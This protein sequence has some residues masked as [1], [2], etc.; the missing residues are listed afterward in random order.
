MF[1]IT[2]LLAAATAAPLPS[3]GDFDATFKTAPPN[4]VFLLDRSSAMSDDCWGEPCIDRARG[5]VESLVQRTDWAHFAA[6]GTASSPEDNTF[7]PIAPLGSSRA[8]LLAALDDIT[9]GSDVRNLGEALASLSLD[10]LAAA[11]GDDGEAPI[12]ADC[13]DTH[14]VVITAGRPRH[15]EHPAAS[16]WLNEAYYWDVRCDTNGDWS[17]DYISDWGC[18]Y[19]NVVS[20]V[21]DIDLRSDLAGSQRIVT[22]TI[23][24]GLDETWATRWLFANASYRTDNEGLYATVGSWGGLDEALAN[25]TDA[26]RGGMTA[27][28]APTLAVDGDR[29]LYAWYDTE[30]GAPLAKGHL[31]AFEIGVNP[32]DPSYYG[33]LTY[34]GPESLGGALWDAGELLAERKVGSRE[35][36]EG[37]RDGAGR[38]DIYTFVPEFMSLDSQ[39]GLVKEASRDGRMSF[40]GAMVDTLASEPWALD[41]LV[42]SGSAELDEPWDMDGDYDVDH[43]DLQSMV[44][45]VRGVPWA[46]F[47]YLYQPRGAWRLGPAPGVAP[48]IL[49]PRDGRYSADPTYRRFLSAI[50]SSGAP[51]VGLLAANDGMLHAFDMA[52]GQELWAWIPATLLY[53]ERGTEWSGLVAD[54][55]QRGQVSLFEGTPTIE[56]VW[57]DLDGDGKKRCFTL[58]DC[59]W[60]R[61]ALTTMGRGGSAVLALD[62][63]NPAGPRFLWEHANVLDEQA[64]GYISAQPVI[65]NML[66]DADADG[67]NE[68]IW[69]AIWPG[70]VAPPASLSA[71]LH[72]AS[73]P[74]VH[75]RPLR[76][77][78]WRSPGDDFRS[79]VMKSRYDIRGDNH[80]PGVGVDIDGDLRAEGGYI[81]GTPALVDLDADGDVDAA[82][83]TVTDSSGDSP[84]SHLYKL[85]LNKTEPASPT[86]CDMGE[87][88]GGD[89]LPAEV[90]YAVT[91]SWMQDGTL[92]LYLGTGSPFDG[93][94]Q[95]EGA[96]VAVVDVYPWSCATTAPICGEDGRLPL[97]AGE[98]LTT[99]P[100]VFDGVTY[101]STWVADP[102]GCGRGEG[103]IYALEYDSCL[104]A[105]DEDGD[106]YTTPFLVVDEYPSS[107]VVSDQGTIFYATAMP[108]LSYEGASAVGELRNALDPFNRVSTLTL[109][110]IF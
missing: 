53:R 22:H 5:A 29:L 34:S 3:A 99:D 64:D 10:E 39:L 42:P 69:T 57:I 26:I 60:R 44:D 101:F 92:G 47:R 48:T 14:V 72:D 96:F 30:D 59:E 28:S 87:V 93:A 58:D 106:G 85:L 63:T 9:P 23:S 94:S 77:D 32:Q 61:V 105:M 56:D 80:H 36:N 43:D 15:D 88:L 54:L 21:Y 78:F 6:V 86:W 110:E 67:Y 71:A 102:S 55:A 35:L 19:D 109:R 98:R 103:R 24:L 104:P 76:D 108:D 40:D 12:C 45:F 38:R 52:D 41:L 20:A 7:T 97:D 83:V 17:A 37:D 91:A 11:P 90:H 84:A 51:T 70:G 73:E 27:T 81:S 1:A 50:E 107:L 8:S 4:I 49:R 74:T 33:R 82:Y 89:D 18:R 16:A 62:I 31:R 95:R 46:R 79:H 2:A 25:V 65:V 68:D 66:D 75:F 100:V 13:Q